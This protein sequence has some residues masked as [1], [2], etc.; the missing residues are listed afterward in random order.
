MPT[1][2]TLPQIRRKLF[3]MERMQRFGD[4]NF[5][6]YLVDGTYLKLFLRIQDLKAKLEKQ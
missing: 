4:G 3:L 1:D 5:Y 6:N 2:M